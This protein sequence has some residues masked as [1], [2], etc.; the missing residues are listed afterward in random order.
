MLTR[1][2]GSTVYAVSTILAAFMAGLALG[3][4]LFGLV[5]DR[6][7]RPL[8]L[9]AAL[10]AGIAI[11]AILSLKMN[12][13]PVPLYRV[14][15][16]MAHES[17]AMLTLVQVL[18]ES[19]VLLVPTMLMG[20]TLPT[21]C[22]YGIRRLRGTG[23]VA[24]T[25]YAINTLGATTGVLLGGFVLIGA[26][27]E[28]NTILLAAGLN[29]TVALVAVTVLPAFSP[30][31][32]VDIEPLEKSASSLRP[33]IA[34]RRIRQAVLICFTASGFAS[35][36]MEIVWS[37]M[38]AL[39]EG[40]SVYAF[41]AMLAVMLAGIGIGC[42][43][44][45]RVERW[46]DPLRALARLEMGV[47]LG[48]AYG[49]IEF[50][51]LPEHAVFLPPLVMIGFPA[52][53][54]GM[55][56][57][58]AVRCFTEYAD[59]L[60][61]R[62]GELYAWNT[63]G[64][65]AGSLAAGF[66][67]L[68]M[69][70]S[71]QTGVIAAVIMGLASALLFLV[72]PNGLRSFGWSGAAM[73]A[74]TVA[75]LAIVGDPYRAMIFNQVG[76]GVS[77]FVV[78]GHVE[79]AAATTTASGIPEVPLERSLLVNG[80][81]M[82]ALITGNKLMADLP[83]WFSDSPRS[84]LVICLG[85]GTTFRSACRHLDVDVTAV[86]L[87]PAVTRFM[88]FYHADADSI[89]AQPNAHVVVDDGRNY[90]LMHDRTFDVITIDPAPPLCSAG[91]VN[92]YTR[93]FFHLCASRLRSSGA[94]CMW[95]PPAPMSDAKMIL[96]SFAT[97]F[98]YVS[99]WAGPTYPGFYLIGTLRPVDD[100]AARIRHGFSN[101][102]VV[103]DLTEWDASCS[104]PEKI[105]ALYVCDREALLR[106]TSDVPPVTDDHPYTEFPLWRVERRDPDYY[107]QL[108]ANFLRQWLSTHESSV[109]VSYPNPAGGSS[110]A[111]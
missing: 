54:L 93:E 46:K 86:E 100:A 36:A 26:I 88:H 53:C 106:F 1:T 24:G 34:S 87:I 58:V 4:F 70:G 37:R 91:T 80:H 10:E 64:C 68:P 47:A 29:L 17:R 7:R 8:L 5:A 45:T 23:R 14:L 49:L 30:T 38:L 25:L 13:W 74:A 31:R 35:L 96:R 104:S 11:A 60:G 18:Y 61:R 99:V 15:Y 22:A 66:V 48:M 73:T 62:V 19:A 27:G 79:E 40:T 65:I 103:A 20:A 55:A 110:G 41:S 108:D 21:L 12:S 111:R 33:S 94:L 92:L 98:P 3:S 107:Q 56:F 28:T 9:Y 59:R 84:A 102:A 83:M 63:L 67:L 6:I 101:P 42:A 109:S 89:M 78:F 16:T 77:G 69:Y 44:G 90:L 75:M 82:T 52:L 2:L 50:S 76:A 105:A 39:Y 32:T 71:S 43:I 81:G 85:M 57:P 72:H 97:T 95:I 51:R